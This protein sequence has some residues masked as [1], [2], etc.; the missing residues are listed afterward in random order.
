MPQVVR[1]LIENIFIYYLI[2][3]TNIQWITT[4]SCFLLLV[5]IVP[6]CPALFANKFTACQAAHSWLSEPFQLLL[7]SALPLP[8][9]FAVVSALLQINSLISAANCLGA[10]AVMLYEM[11]DGLPLLFVINTGGE[12]IQA[13]EAFLT[14]TG[15]GLWLPHPVWFGTIQ[16]IP[17]VACGIVY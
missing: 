4:P 10:N 9:L 17:T 3:T 6:L 11:G 12:R 7:F 5:H 13:K 2:C 1:I 14:F 15:K 16:V 8:V